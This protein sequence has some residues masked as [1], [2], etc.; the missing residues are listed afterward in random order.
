MHIISVDMPSHTITSTYPHLRSSLV[1]VPRATLF[2]NLMPLFKIFFYLPTQIP[3]AASCRLSFIR[4]Y[5]LRF[6]IYQHYHTTTN[7]TTTLTQETA[8]TEVCCIRPATDTRRLAPRLEP[9]LFKYG[10][11]ITHVGYS[12]LPE[13]MVE[14]LMGA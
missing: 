9:S 12:A 8:W 4:N 13:H 6:A 7:T 1:Y 10:N 3:L 14:E 11:G 2:R 5:Y